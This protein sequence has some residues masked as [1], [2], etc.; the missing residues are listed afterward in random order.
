M[1]VAGLA[2]DHVLQVKHVCHADCK[3]SGQ[4][5]SE[6]WAASCT[7]ASARLPVLSSADTGREFSLS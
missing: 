4:T 2:L 5:E 6:Q 3:H 7:P 1:S